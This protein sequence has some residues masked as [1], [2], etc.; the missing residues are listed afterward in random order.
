MSARDLREYGYETV[1]GE[2]RNLTGR[3]LPDVEVVVQWYTDNDA[4]IA[5]EEALIEVNPIPAGHTCPFKVLTKA[6][7]AMAR[8]SL[9][10]KAMFDPATPTATTR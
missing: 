6:N 8:Y 1:E 7:P 3:A 9:A 5:I 10:F 4:L 2:V